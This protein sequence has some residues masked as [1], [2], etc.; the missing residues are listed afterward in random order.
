[1]LPLLIVWKVNQVELPYLLPRA[2]CKCYNLQ[3]LLSAESPATNNG[4]NNSDF[5]D[6]DPAIDISAFIQGKHLQ[7]IRSYIITSLSLPP[8]LS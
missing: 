6:R 7:N 4:T 1:M 5:N 2:I 3:F 8:F